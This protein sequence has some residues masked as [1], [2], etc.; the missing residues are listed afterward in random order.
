MLSRDEHVCFLLRTLESYRSLGEEGNARE[1]QTTTHACQGPRL[2]NPF[3]ALC[4]CFVWC[5]CSVWFVCRICVVC[6]VYMVCVY[7]CVVCGVYDVSVMCYYVCLVCMC[8]VVCV[9]RV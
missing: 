3:L 9:V 1:L 5:A 4:V 7:V 2:P 8:G 6:D